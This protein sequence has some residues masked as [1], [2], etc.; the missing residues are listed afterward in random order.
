MNLVCEVKLCLCVF[1]FLE[2]HMKSMS[3]QL[4]D[5]RLFLISILFF[6]LYFFSTSNLTVHLCIGVSSWLFFISYF[7]LL[8]IVEHWQHTLV[9]EIRELV[10]PEDRTRYDELVYSRD[11]YLSDRDRHR[12]SVKFIF[13]FKHFEQSIYK[14]NE[15]FWEKINIHWLNV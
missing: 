7:F 2:L 4:I 9:T 10:F 6:A 12:V 5:S 13:K 14:L 15:L 8:W 3:F 11:P 1:K